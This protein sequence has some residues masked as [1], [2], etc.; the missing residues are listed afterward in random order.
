MMSSLPVNPRSAGAFLDA[1]LC[2]SG[3]NVGGASSDIPERRAATFFFRA[4]FSPQ[5][6]QGDK[7]GVRA[8]GVVPS[9]NFNGEL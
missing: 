6:D 3:D 7:L 8:S 1:S 2:L 4:G 5:V 9:S